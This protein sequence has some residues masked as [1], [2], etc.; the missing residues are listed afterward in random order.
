MVYI[1]SNGEGVRTLDGSASWHPLTEAQIS[2]VSTRQNELLGSQKASVQKLVSRTPFKVYPNPSTSC[3]KISYPS[4]LVGDL[5][6]EIFDANGSRREIKTEAIPGSNEVLL[7]VSGLSNGVYGYTLSTK[8]GV[9]SA[10]FV[11]VH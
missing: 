6:V 4:T 11:V 3:V 9:A 5:R 7:D 1:N 2:R 10:S 8:S